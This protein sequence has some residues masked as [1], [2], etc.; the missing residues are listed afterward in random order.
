MYE[1]GDKKELGGFAR[2]ID[3]LFTGASEPEPAPEVEAP[4]A[5]IDPFIDLEG[6]AVSGVGAALEPEMSF[7]ALA[8]DAPEEVEMSF[9]ALAPDAPE[10]VEMSFDALAP[11]AP[12]EVEMSFDALA[13]D[14]P[15]D[16]VVDFASLAPDPDEEVLLAPESEPLEG[17]AAADV[18]REEVPDEVKEAGPVPALAD[19]DALSAALDAFLA[20][21]RLEGERQAREIHQM[22]DALRAAN[23]LEPLADAVERLVTEASDDEASLALADLMVTAGVASRIAARLGTERDEERRQHL[24]AVCKAVGLEMAIAISDALSDT[25]DRFARRSFMDAMVMFGSTGMVVVEQMVE[26][27]RWFVIRNAVAILGEVGG[28]RAVELITSTLAHTDGRV[29]REALLALAKL[30]GEDAGML[31]Y[32]MLQDPDPD[33][34]LAAAMAAGELKVERALKPLLGILDSESDESVTVA[35]LQA[36]GK[37][38]DPGAVNSIAKRATVSFFSKSPLDVRIA[39]YRALYNIGTPHAKRLI[40]QAVDDKDPDVKAAV[41]DM[42]GMI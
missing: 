29:R 42:I 20:S 19:P 39:A 30:G 15:E 26:D 28:D 21:P 10:E 2:S 37:L 9:D 3:A 12:E 38:G 32:G 13:P 1:S 16:I 41:R 7:D 11:D 33:A 34:R 36:L 4:D 31:V 6:A 35:I 24:F 5:D 22:V 18:M 27:N 8:P 23:A 17:G 40:N 25:N 14:A